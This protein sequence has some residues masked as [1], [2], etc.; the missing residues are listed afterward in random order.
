MLNTI[1]RVIIRVY[2]IIYSSPVYMGSSELNV[3]VSFHAESVFLHRY[4]VGTTRS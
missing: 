1:V 2:I 3:L 4:V